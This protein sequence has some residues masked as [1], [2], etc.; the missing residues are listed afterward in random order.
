[1]GA[2]GPPALYHLVFFSDQVDGFDLVIRASGEGSSVSY[3]ATLQA[4][5]KAWQE[6]MGD[7][8][9]RHNVIELIQLVPVMGL[10]ITT[11]DFLVVFG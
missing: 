6:V 9:C 3:L 11:N 2:R 1:M 5:R 10:P 4:G 7:E 8:I